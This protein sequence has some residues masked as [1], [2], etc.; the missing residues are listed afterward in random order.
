MAGVKAFSEP[1]MKIFIGSSTEYNDLALRVAKCIQEC[2]G[3][4]KRWTD[5]D[6]FPPG[7][8]IWDRLK[9]LSTQFDGA[10]F[11]FGCDDRV[12]SRDKA[13]YQPRDNVLLEFGLFSGRL[14]RQ[15]VA[16]YRVGGSKTAVDLEGLTYIDDQ[17][18][19][20]GPGAEIE[21]REW[22]SNL[23]TVGQE[24]ADE[25]NSIFPFIEFKA[26]DERAPRVRRF[27]S[28]ARDFYGYAGNAD[29]SNKS[30]EELVENLKYYIDPPTAYWDD[31]V[32]DQVSVVKKYQEGK[33]PLAQVPIRFNRQHPKFPEKTF[34]PLIAES[35]DWEGCHITRILYL[36]IAQLPKGVFGEPIWLDLSENIDIE[37]LSIELKQIADDWIRDTPEVAR[38]RVKALTDA[39][40]EAAKGG[41]IKVVRLCGEAGFFA[42]RSFAKKGHYPNAQLLLRRVLALTEDSGSPSV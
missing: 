20:L 1:K 25:I 15:A 36:E 18:G 21:V 5:D 41:S 26:N 24:A 3:E 10:I 42:V 34:V 12:E 38:A 32:N 37:K 33:L 8:Y 35:R 22:F 9:Q 14:P 2:G 17:E 19:K 29:L 27:S 7:V 11:L 23:K 16:F 28:S 4:A 30:V 6:L 40:D 39:A 13:G 31:F